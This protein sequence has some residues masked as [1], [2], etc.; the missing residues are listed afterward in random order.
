M[1]CFSTRAMK[2]AGVYRAKADL[3]KCGLAERK[4]SGWQN[5]FVKLQRP[6][7]EIRIFLPARSE[8]SRTATRRPRLPASIAHI[9]P[10]APAPRITASNL[11]T[12]V[13][14]V[15]EKLIHAAREA[16]NPL[17]VENK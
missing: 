2:S 15:R 9:S 5:K 14:I 4:C 17:L 8:R 6:P 10:A 11:W 7:P 16:H 13:W 12:I 1:P 3:A